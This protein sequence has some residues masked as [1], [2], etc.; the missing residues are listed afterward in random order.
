[1]N[2]AVPTAYVQD[3][4]TGSK[5]EEVNT[6]VEHPDL[7]IFGR[8]IAFEKQSMMN[9]VAPEGAIKEGERVIV[10]S[11]LSGSD[12]GESDHRFWNEYPPIWFEGKSTAR[13]VNFPDAEVQ[14]SD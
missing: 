3:T 9:V 5:I 14:L 7:S 6:V 2:A 12:L 1:V 13:R 4:I 11:D 8:F 10:L